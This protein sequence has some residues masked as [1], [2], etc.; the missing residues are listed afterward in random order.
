MG[1]LKR[2]ES[3]D[4][5]SSNFGKWDFR[6]L[7]G[8]NKIILCCENKRQRIHRR[9]SDNTEEDFCYFTVL[10][11]VHPDFVFVYLRVMCL[12]FLVVVFTGFLETLL[13]VWLDW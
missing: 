6:H 4:R 12:C 9:K 8:I 3:E 1:V 13:L 2:M 5:A 7:E 10:I 11:N